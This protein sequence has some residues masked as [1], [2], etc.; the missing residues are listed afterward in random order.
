MKISL[1]RPTPSDRQAELVVRLLE[2]AKP[3]ATRL[4][5]S[6]NR[7]TEMRAEAARQYVTL[8]R[9]NLEHARAEGVRR[10]E[11]RV[12]AQRYALILALAGFG[13]AAYA[14]RLGHPTHATVVAGAS[15]LGIVT[16]MLRSSRHRDDG[17]DES[18]DDE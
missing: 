10:R 6:V 3:I 2:G 17:K 8:A 11:I 14:F 12:R 9:D 15:L 18:P 5:D 16:A 7:E 13:L 1:P 4:L